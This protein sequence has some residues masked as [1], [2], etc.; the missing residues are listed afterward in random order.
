MHIAKFGLIAAFTTI[1]SAC[2]TEPAPVPASQQAME[3]AII[4]VTASGVKLS[5]GDRV[6]WY[7]GAINLYKDERLQ[8]QSIQAELEKQIKLNVIERKLA[9]VDAVSSADY[10]IAYTAGLESAI[11]DDQILMRFGLSP[12]AVNVPQNTDEYEKG[13]LVIYLFDTQTGNVVWRSAAQAAVDLNM[14]MDER[15]QRIARLVQRMFVSMP[16]QASA[17]APASAGY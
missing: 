5:E 16:A 8:S 1:L 2:V 10:T 6:S 13:T 3:P 4:S 17:A 7:P 11:G 9:F 12:G 15:R 14:S